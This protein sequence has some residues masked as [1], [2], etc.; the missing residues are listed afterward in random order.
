[1][2]VWPDVN[3]S[4]YIRFQFHQ[5]HRKTIFNVNLTLA[6]T[7][8]VIWP[9]FLTILL[10]C[11]PLFIENHH[12]LQKK[13]D[14]VT[15]QPTSNFLR[16]ILGKYFQTVVWLNFLDNEISAHILVRLDDFHDFIGI[17]PTIF[18]VPTPRME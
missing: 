10:I 4:W 6:I 7:W 8:A 13:V 1:M 18:D 3:N 5:T 9:S 17:F 15:F 11:G 12:T 14:F 16:S 2:S